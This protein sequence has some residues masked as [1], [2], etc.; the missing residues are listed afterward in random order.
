[1]TEPNLPDV[2]AEIAEIGDVSIEAGWYALRSFSLKT[3]QATQEVADVLGGW[4]DDG[5]CKYWGSGSY[6]RWPD[7]ADGTCTAVCR[8]SSYQAPQ[9]P[10]PAEGCTCG[11]YASLSYADLIKQFRQD[12]QR[13]VC[14]INAEGSTIIGTRGLK[15]AHARIVAYWTVPSI[16]ERTVAKMQFKG[17]KQFDE[18]LSMIE[19]YQIA[20][21]PPPADNRHSG[22]GP[23]WWTSGQHGSRD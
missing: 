3:E 17:A 18:P 1:M 14:V 9:H 11:I 22:G 15:T 7:W 2:A 23:E 10:P 16:L 8:K 19:H 21:L 4:W 6:G 5:T 13:I 20:L 12:A